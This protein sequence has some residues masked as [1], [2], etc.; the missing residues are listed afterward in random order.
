MFEIFAETG[1]YAFYT[2]VAMTALYFICAFFFDMYYLSIP[3]TTISI[4][5]YVCIAIYL[6]LS[7]SPAVIFARVISALALFGLF[8]LSARFFDSGGGDAIVLPMLALLWG[9]INAAFI[10]LIGCLITTFIVILRALIKHEKIA[11]RANY[12][13]LP[14]ISVSYIVFI[15]IYFGTMLF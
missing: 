4:T 13:L 6:F 9:I 3:W 8:Y 14:G 15:I 10:I 11:W 5:A 12:P 2:A 1:S 7:S